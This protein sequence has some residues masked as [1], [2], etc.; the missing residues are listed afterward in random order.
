MLAKIFGGGAA[1][2]DLKAKLAAISRSQAVIEFD[3]TGKILDANDNFLQTLGYS[4]SE[5]QGKHHSMFVDP[6]EREGVEYKAFW[7]RLRNGEF[8]SEQFK[9]IGA[10]GREVWIQ[11]TYNPILDASGKP[12]KV[13]KFATE[14][15]ARKLRAANQEGQ[16]NAI[17]KAQA[18]IEFNLDGT[19]IAANGNFE[20]TMGYSFAEIE[21]KHHSMFVDPTYAA[22]EEYKKFWAELRRG[23]F[24]AGEYK[25]FA[26]GNQEIWLQ[27][28]YNPIFDMNGK[29]FKVVKFASD[30][31]EQ[32]TLMADQSGQMDAISQSMA[33]IQFD[34]NGNILTAN[35]NF[36]S[37]LGYGLSEIKGRHHSIFVDSDEVKSSEYQ[38]F[39]ADLRKG[40]FQAGEFKHIG[41]NS[42]EVWIQATYNPIFDADDKL[43]KVV[44]FATNITDQVMARQRGQRV[45]DMMSTVAS[46]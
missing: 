13:V 10:G 30:I 4:L 37:T 17:H 46:G 36:L 39:W 32:K 38:K 22:S 25:R 8:V 3:L 43:I 6:A 19:I 12:V 14:T 18:V 7:D 1:A 23:E 9:R 20:S 42:Q 16:I 5:I 34:T 11:A 33:V 21:G 35:Q 24:H 28:S 45:S 15:T 29:P 26:N 41:K 31:T 2:R 27:A 44:K 40:E